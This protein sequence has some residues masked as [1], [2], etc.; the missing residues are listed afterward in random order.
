MRQLG[1]ITM[2]QEQHPD[3]FLEQV[4]QLRDELV[5]MG[6]VISEERLTGMVIEGTIG[7]YDQ[8]K[9]NTERDPDFSIA[10][11]ES[12]MRNMYSNRMALKLTA[13]RW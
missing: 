5:H 12:T 6:E 10:D 7:D 3:V 8:I 11:I 4:Y 13:G 2:P 1:N 9:Y